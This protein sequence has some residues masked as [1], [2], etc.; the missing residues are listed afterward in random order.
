MSVYKMLLCLTC[1]TGGVG[2]GGVGT[3]A[4]REAWFVLG[5]T[6]W[7]LLLLAACLLSFLW[8]RR[9]LV[10]YRENRLANAYKSGNGT[11]SA[12]LQ[13]SMDWHFV[14]FLDSRSKYGPGSRF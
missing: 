6:L 7:L 2:A 12:G 5:T 1:C 10:S 13:I 9:R 3:E 4:A 14:E 8:Q 11:G